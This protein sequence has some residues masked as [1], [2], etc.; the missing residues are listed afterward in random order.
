MKRY[1]ISTIKFH[2]VGVGCLKTDSGYMIK[3]NGEYLGTR[4]YDIYNPDG[5]RIQRNVSGLKDAREMVADII[6]GRIDESGREI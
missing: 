2:K 6:E 4:W 3:P 5:E 1:I